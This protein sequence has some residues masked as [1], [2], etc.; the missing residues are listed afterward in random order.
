[1]KILGISETQYD[2]P[3]KFICEISV[4]ELGCL[5][6]DIYKKTKNFESLQ[7]GAEINLSCVYRYAEELQKL[8]EHMEK[9]IEKFES[10]K[11]VMYKFARAFGPEVE[12]KNKV[13]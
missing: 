9:T 5:Y 11:D 4:H 13:N 1:M 2:T 12:E 3:K 10:T 8:F 7:P 6:N